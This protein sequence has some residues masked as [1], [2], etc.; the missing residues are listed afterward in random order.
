LNVLPRTK[1]SSVTFASRA[2]SIARV[3]GADTAATTGTPVINDDDLRPETE[4]LGIGNV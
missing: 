1:P 3:D 2:N 4:R